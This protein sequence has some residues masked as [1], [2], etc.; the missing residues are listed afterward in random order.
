M[1]PKLFWNNYYYN[2]IRKNYTIN[3]I[4]IFFHEVVMFAL[5]SPN[6]MKK[7]FRHTIRS[8]LSIKSVID[9]LHG[10]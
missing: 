9:C 2:K 3:K 10:T 7:N 4:F 5:I 8:Q 1:G 6:Y